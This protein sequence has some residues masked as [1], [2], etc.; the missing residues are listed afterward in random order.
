M[1]TTADEQSRGAGKLRVPAYVARVREGTA[2]TI[3]GK[4][5][6]TAVTADDVATVYDEPVWDRRLMQ[7]VEAT[8]YQL[9]TRRSSMTTELDA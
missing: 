6:L 1:A 5:E 2:W 3:P 8:M 4:E 9:A 7:T